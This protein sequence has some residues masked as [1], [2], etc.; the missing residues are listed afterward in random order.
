M[1]LT[2]HVVPSMSDALE[3]L[4][5]LLISAE[6]SM[7][8]RVSQHGSYRIGKE[9]SLSPKS[10]PLDGRGNRLIMDPV[11]RP[12]CFIPIR[13]WFRVNTSKTTTIGKLASQSGSSGQSVL[14]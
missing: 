4:E 10:N 7:A 9:N 2:P 11:A 12:C 3:Q 6:A 5:E 8:L 1:A 13:R 14:F